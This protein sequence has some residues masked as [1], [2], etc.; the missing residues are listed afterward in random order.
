MVLLFALACGIDLP[1]EGILDRTRILAARTEPAQPNVGETFTVTSY[2]YAPSGPP[3]VVWCAFADCDPR[4]PL[5]TELSQLDWAALTEDEQR[6]R[7]SK[8]LQ[9]GILGVEPGLPVVATATPVPG[10]SDVVLLAYGVPPEGDD[11]ETATLTLAVGGETSTAHP[12]IETVRVDERAVAEVRLE[13]DEPVTLDVVTDADVS[14]R[15]YTDAPEPE[16]MG[17]GGGGPAF[18]DDGTLELTVAEPF[19]GIVV[20]VVRDEV[21]GV[22]WREL[23][24]VVQ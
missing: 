11:I 1:S 15:W 20:V 18:L 2:A 12:A 5:V 8:A 10:T 13:V 23:P 24:L 19:S 7:R 22:D 3:T 4:A 17:F 14:V 6:A 16:G 21:G 9:A